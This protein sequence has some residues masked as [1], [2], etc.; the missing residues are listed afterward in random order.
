MRPFA[1][2]C[3]SAAPAS[4]QHFS[5]GSRLLQQKKTWRA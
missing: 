5:G 3:I 2:A 4:A 1:Y